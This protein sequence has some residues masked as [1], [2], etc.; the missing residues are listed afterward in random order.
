MAVIPDVN[1]IQR[2]AST[3]TRQPIVRQAG[4]P[5]PDAMSGLANTLGDLE[6]K[7]NDL[8]LTKAMNRFRIGR[9]QALSRQDERADFENIENDWQSE[10]RELADLVEQGITD[11]NVREHFRGL[12]E[13]DIESDRATVQDLVFGKQTDA[14]MGELL[15]TENEYRKAALHPDANLTDL[16]LE[17]QGRHTAM[18]NAGFLSREEAER[19]NIEFRNGVAVDRLTAMPAADRMAM[20]TW[21]R[22][23]A[24]RVRR[25]SRSSTAW[26]WMPAWSIRNRCWPIRRGSTPLIA[27]PISA[28][29]SRARSVSARR[30]AC[31]STYRR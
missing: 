21:C 28:A 24:R 6:Q 16:A 11:G 2:R 9:T 18:V 3:A 22:P 25:S 12:A 29:S 14:E 23:Y 13:V 5:L 31:R 17:M 8:E 26:R 4:N 27:L 15:E 30:C 19:R 10:V 20:S 1:N 7:R